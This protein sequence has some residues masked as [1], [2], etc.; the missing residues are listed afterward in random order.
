MV[1]RKQAE[2]NRTRIKRNLRNGEENR[3]R[4]MP[5]GN[6]TRIQRQGG[7]CVLREHSGLEALGWGLF[8]EMVQTP[9]GKCSINIHRAVSQRG[10]YHLLA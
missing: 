5:C 1:L 2:G 9:L 8:E 7:E 3:Q 6:R 10:L 4:F